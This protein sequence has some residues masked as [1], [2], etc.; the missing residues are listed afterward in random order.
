MVSRLKSLYGINEVEEC[1]EP[2]PDHFSKV[3]GTSPVDRTLQRHWRAD[4]EITEVC[5]GAEVPD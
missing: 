3:E 1:V 4:Y 5:P 2:L